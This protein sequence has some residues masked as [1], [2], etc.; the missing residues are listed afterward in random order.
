MYI[1][2]YCLK[3]ILVSD[4]HVTHRT[5][6]SDYHVTHRTQGIECQVSHCTKGSDC[7]VTHLKVIYILF[8][9]MF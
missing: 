5:Q 1:P 6:G 2:N 7:H 8:E 9:L 4:C 3:V